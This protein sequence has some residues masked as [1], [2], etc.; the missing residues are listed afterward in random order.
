M[1]RRQHDYRDP[2]PPGWE[3]CPP[4]GEVSPLHNLIPMK[5]CGWSGGGGVSQRQAHRD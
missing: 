4:I 5:V 3:Q 1:T 2:V